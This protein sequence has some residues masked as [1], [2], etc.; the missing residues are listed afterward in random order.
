MWTRMLKGQVRGLLPRLVLF[1]LVLSLSLF[2]ALLRFFFGG[3][4]GG[5]QQE[6]AVSILEK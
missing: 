2:H 3:G 5:G 1:P 4:G 6:M